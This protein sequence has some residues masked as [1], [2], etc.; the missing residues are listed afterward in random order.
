M[1][2]TWIIIAATCIVSLVYMQNQE[3]KS[4]FMFNAYAIRHRGEWWRFFTGALLHADGTHLFFNMITFYFFG[5]TVEAAFNGQVPSINGE[6]YALNFKSPDLFDHGLG[7]LMFFLMY[8]TAIPLS[9][10]YSYFKH[11]DDPY[12]NA[13][14][15]SGAVSAVLYTFIL[16]APTSKLSIFFAIP[17]TGWI[18]GIIYL[19][20]CRV[21]AKRNVGN[22]GHDAHFFGSVYGFL[23]PLIFF[24]FLAENFVFQI[25]QSLSR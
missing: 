7:S 8:V 25:T 16:L 21:L 19:I 14:G 6:L 20:I 10:L 15:A 12:Y 9:S 2:V 1:Y 5:E 13:L 18:Y 23:F 24:P 22:I 3:F 17:V 11:K 4:R